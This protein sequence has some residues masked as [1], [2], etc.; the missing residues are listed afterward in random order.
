MVPNQNQIKVSFGTGTHTHM[1]AEKD[2]DKDDLV[3][4]IKQAFEV[5]LVSSYF[6]PS[7]SKPISN[8]IGRTPKG[9][10]N[11]ELSFSP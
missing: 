7:P 4:L 10:M 2:G 9:G 1:H 11:W 6:W 3:S 5:T 8:E